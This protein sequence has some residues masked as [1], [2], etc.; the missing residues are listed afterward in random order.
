MTKTNIMLVGFMGT[1]KTTVGRMLAERLNK[2]FVDMDHKIEERAGK[3]IADIFAQEG[4]AH[5]R[6]LER[7]LVQELAQE[8]N[9]VVAAG[10]GV[11]LNPMNLEDFSKT[12]H[13]ICLKAS[14]ETILRRVLKSSHRPLLEEGDKRQKIIELMKEREPLYDAVPLSVNTACLSAREV[15]DDICRLL[16]QQNTSD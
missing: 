12:G 9:L 5:F 11:V 4:E 13:V 14:H 16:E 3:K 7:A 8:E 6:A 15:T 1:G 10:G 2:T